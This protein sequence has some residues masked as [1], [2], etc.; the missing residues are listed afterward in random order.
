MTATV[1]TSRTARRVHAIDSRATWQ[2]LDWAV[3]L[4][5][6]ALLTLGS[7]LVWSAT[8]GNGAL[9]GGER[10]AFVSKHVTNIAIGLVL[11]AVIAATDHRWVRIWAPIVYLGGVL[12]LALVLSPLGAVINGSRSW[13]LIGGMSIQPAEFAKLGVVAGMSLLLAERAEARRER[14]SL[15]SWEVVATLALAAAPLL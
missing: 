13:I 12:G 11:A 9:T 7:L 15:R 10:T 1:A 4:A 8:A 3:V 5:T 2:R 14:K 6:V